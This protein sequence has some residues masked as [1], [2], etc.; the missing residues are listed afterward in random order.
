MRL[1]MVMGVNQIMEKK[2]PT[3]AK[4]TKATT[5]KKQSMWK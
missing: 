4:M 5:K 2:E 1:A 3:S